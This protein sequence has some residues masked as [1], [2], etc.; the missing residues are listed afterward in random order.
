M[1]VEKVIK[2]ALPKIKDSIRIYKEFAI[3]L[4]E[5]V[6]N[7]I[8]EKMKYREVIES[9]S[10]I[11]L[12]IVTGLLCIATFNLG[13]YTNEMSS[14]TD[15][16]AKF[17]EHKSTPYMDVKVKAISFG[18]RDFLLKIIVRNLSE[19]YV[20][21]VYYKMRIIVTDPKGEKFWFGYGSPKDSG[22]E[23]WANNLERMIVGE[24]YAPQEKT[25]FLRHLIYNEK[26]IEGLIS[27]DWKLNVLVKM[28]YKDKIVGTMKYYYANYYYDHDWR[29][30][31]TDISGFMMRL[32]NRPILNKDGEESIWNNG[33]TDWHKQNEKIN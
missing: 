7:K 24:T 13:D 4:D 3:K 8:I 16:L 10:T 30:K 31:D 19:I 14:A 15:K 6:C 12:V 32:K 33:K 20:P 1:N 2:L 26:E 25:V 5:V 11:A 17:E 27:G 21:K 18:N 9:I 29:Y 22:Q 23:D 28:V